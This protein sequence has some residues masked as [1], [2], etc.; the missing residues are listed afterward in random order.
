[1]PWLEIIKNNVIG[2]LSGRGLTL[3]YVVVAVISIL[4]LMRG[5]LW[6]IRKRTSDSQ[7]RSVRFIAVSHHM[8]IAC[9]PV[10]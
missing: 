4:I 3:I 8:V 5:I 6:L 9:L 10:S 1:M 7:D 2:F